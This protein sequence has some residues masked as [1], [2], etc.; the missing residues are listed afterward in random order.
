MKTTNKHFYKKYLLEQQEHTCTYCGVFIDERTATIDHINPR[1]NGGEDSLENF[2][3]CCHWCNQTKTDYS[4]E[5]FVGFIE[6]LTGKSKM[7]KKHTA[8]LNNFP[9]RKP[10]EKETGKWVGLYNRLLKRRSCKIALDKVKSE[11][12]TSESVSIGSEDIIP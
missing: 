7:K 11:Y 9:T 4:K 10:N 6:Y 1:I 2:T 12:E 3:L 5:W 8:N